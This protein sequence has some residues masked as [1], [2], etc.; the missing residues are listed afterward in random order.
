MPE[1]LAA[2]AAILSRYRE[3]FVITRDH[4]NASGYE[5]APGISETLN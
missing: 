5:H 1:A 2:D 4:G 3:P